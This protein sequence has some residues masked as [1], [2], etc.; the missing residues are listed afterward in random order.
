MRR[1][2]FSSHFMPHDFPKVACELD[3]FVGDNCFG[4]PV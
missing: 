1:L 4:Q 3:I 2:M